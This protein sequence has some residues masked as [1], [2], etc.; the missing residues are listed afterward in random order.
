MTEWQDDLVFG[1]IVIIFIANMFYPFV[2]AKW[3]SGRELLFW[4]MIIKLCYIP[5]YVLVF[6]MGAV[7]MI[8]PKG[9]IFVLFLMIF[10]YL[11]LLPSTMYGV[12]GLMKASKEGKISRG[13]A[14]IG[15]IL[16]FF[17]CTDVICAAVMYFIVKGRDK[18]GEASVA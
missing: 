13:I 2:A 5:I 4:D 6:V 3:T 1:C 15:I 16:H 17:F 8:V 11:L 10:D 12:S 9:L 14:V 7:L 18:K